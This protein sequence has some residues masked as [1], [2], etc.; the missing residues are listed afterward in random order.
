MNHKNLELLMLRDK[1][2]EIDDNIL[3][4]LSKRQLLSAK[5]AKVKLKHNSQIRDKARERLIL[6]R[7][8]IYGKQYKL[9]SSYIT[10]LFHL[11]IED[12]IFIQQSILQK[13]L[14]CAYANTAKIS[15]L[16][17]KGSYSHIAARKYSMRYFDDIIEFS[18]LNFHDV[19]YNVENGIADYAILP[20]ENTASGSINEVYD[21][22]QNTNLSIVNELFL[23]IDHCILS[24]PDTNLEKIKIIYSH[25]QPFQQ[26]SNFI[27]LF[28][29]WS[30]KYTESTAAAM[31]KVSKLNSSEIAALGSEDGGILYTLKVLKRNIANQQYNQTRFIILSRKSIE[32]SNNVPAKTTFVVETGQNVSSLVDI[33]LVL[34]NYSLVINKIESRPINGNPWEEI[35][36]IDIKS[37]LKSINMKN[38]IKDL[39][40]ITCSLKILGC[41][42]SESYLSIEYNKH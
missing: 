40:S 38:A 34:R 19:V 25:L 29:H 13:D 20:I 23:H 39:N 6:D 30:L 21:L 2:N 33:L 22:L 28:P 11:I 26:C 3:I 41:Y 35:F 18:C 27:S 32:V 12:S 36:Y 8:I 1:I 14:N 10:K 37:N 9:D 31:K 17:P 4:L 24:I 7:L 42:P 15:F 16:G 5:I